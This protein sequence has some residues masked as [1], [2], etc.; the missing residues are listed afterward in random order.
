M[1]II[2]LALIF[3]GIYYP[4]RHFYA[5]F[6][7]NGWD[8]GPMIDA[9]YVNEATTALT[10]DLTIAALALMVWVA[11][12]VIT[13]RAWAWLLVVPVTFGIGVSA[14]LPLALLLMTVQRRAPGAS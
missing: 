10:W 1:R 2:Y 4:W 13:K 8:L 7:E 12:E 6:E 3:A 9:W 11:H 14:G 5:W